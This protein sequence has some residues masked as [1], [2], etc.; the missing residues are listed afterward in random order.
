MLSNRQFAQKIENRRKS[1]VSV[2]IVFLMITST[3]LGLIS[4]VSQEFEV[5]SQLVDADPLSMSEAQSTDQGGQG[6][7]N[8]RMPSQY[9]LQMHDAL[10]DL[11]WSDSSTM[12]G[13]IE[14]ISALS[15]DPGY[16]LMLEESA[17]D[18]H[19]NDGINDLDDLDD[20]ND[21]IY[22][23]L[24]RFDGCVETDPY[25]HD[26]DGIQDHLDWDDDN[27]GILEG[28]I[29]YD[30]LEALGLD[31]R[32]V[33]MHRYVE[34]STIHPLTGQPVGISYRAD[35]QPFDHD[36]DGVTDEDTDGSGAGRY[37][38]DDDNDG[39]IDQFRWPCDFD[40]DGAQD[41]FDDDDDN[42]GTADWLD[43]APYDSTIFT[44]MDA[45]GNLWD[46]YRIWTF[47]EYR[48]YSAGV[49][50]IDLEAAKVDAN[51]EFDFAGGETGDGAAGT[52]AF[53]TISDGDLDGDGIPNFIDPDNDDDDVPDSS[54]TDDDNDGLLDMYDP[55]DDNDGIPD[56]CWNI[57]VNG[58]GLNDYTGL[59]STPYQTPGA[60]ADNDGFIDCEMDY[61]ADLDDDRFRPFDQNYNAIW[62][63]LDDGYNGETPGSPEYV[64]QER[65]DMGGTPTPD[66]AVQTQFLA[67]DFAYDIDNDQIENENDSFPLDQNSEAWIATCTSQSNPNPANP[68]PRCMTRRASFAQFN[69]WDGDGISNWDDVDDDGDGIIDMLDIDWDCDLDN[70]ALL[71]QINGSKYRDDGPNDVD[72][73]IDGDGLS[74]DIDWDDDNDGINDLY[75]PD[76]GNCGKVDYDATDSFATPY[77]PLGDGADLDGSEDNQDYS[78]NT[79]N[80]WS[81]VWNANPFADVILN[82]N[83][84]DATTNPPEGGDVPEFYWF[85]F[86]RWSSYNGANEWDI[87]ADGDSLI[88]GLD[89]DQD[90][91]GMPD[92][93][94][95]DE[96]NDGLM[97]V[98]DLKMGGTMNLTQCG[99]TVG[100]LGSGFTCGYAYAIAYHMPLTGTNAQ[101]GSPY[102]TR[103]DAA[104]DQGAGGKSTWACT[105]GAQGGCWHYDFGG[106]GDVESAISYTQIQDNRDAF[107]TWMGLLT[108]IWQWNFDDTAVADTV[109]FPD[110]LGADLLHNAED[111]DVDGD[112]TNNTVDLDED[113]DNIYD[114]NDVDDDND[115]LWD[116]FEVDT[117]DD[118]DDDVDQDY[119][120]DFFTGL[121]CDDKDDDGND[122]DVD[123]DGWFQA[124]WD[125]GIM[126]QGLKSPKF[127]DVDNDNDG[128]PDSEDPDDDNNG[129]MDAQQELQPGCFTG[130]EQ[131]PFDHDNDGIVDWADNDFDGDGISNL[132]EAQI[133]IT[134]PFDHDNDGL[135]D[136]IDKD[137]DEDGMQD[138][139]EVLLWPLRFDTESTNP[140]DH[141][142]YGGGLG[143]ANPLDPSTGP[144]AID[145]DD[146]NDSRED[147]DWDHLEENFISDPC[148]NGAQSSD[149]DH[150][151]NCILDADDKAPTFITMDMPDNLW[152]DAQSPAIFRGHVDWL[153]PTTS[154]LEAAPGLPVQVHIEWT[155]NNTTAIETIDVITNMWGNFTVGQF[156]FPEDL[157]VG[158]NTTYRV[159]AEVTEMFAFNG[160]QSQSYF[161]GAEANMTVD[162]SAWTY[163]RSDEQ[164]FWLDF[165]AH[166]A[167]DWTRGLYDNRI[168]NSPISFE[169]TDGPGGV[170]GNTTNPSNYSGFNNDGYRTDDDG[171]AS[172][173]FVQNLGANG[174]WKQVRWNS[175]MDNGVGLIP[176]G[177]EEI[178]WNDLTKTHDVLLDNQGMPLR[179]NYTNTSLPAGD[180]EIKASV[181]PGLANEW[182]FPYLH[183][184]SSDPFPV[185]VMHRM[186][187]EG[188]MI[189]DGLSAVYY[190]DGT[191][192]NGDG[193][194]GNWATLFHQQALNA[195]GV[196]F[197]EAN[198]LRPYPS[199][200]D[201]DPDNLPGEAI[202][203]RSF[204]TVNATHWF[205]SL[206]N[207][208]DGDLP[209]CG[210]VDPTDPSSPVRCEIVPEMN[211]GESFGVQGKVTNRTND[212]WDQDPIALQID[213]DGNGQFMGSQETA[214]TQRPVMKNGEATFEYNWTWYSQYAAGTYG[215][216]VDFTNNAY[217]FTGNSTNLAATGAYINVT[218]VGTT[219]FQM[220]SVPRLYRNSTTIIEARLLDNSLQPLRQSP[221]TWTW[222]YDGRS[223]V[224]FTDDMGTFA[225]PFDI[226]PEDDLGNYSL[227]FEYEGNRLMK[228]NVDSQSVWVVSRTYVSVISSD[229]NIRESGDRWDFTAQITDD[230]KTATIRDAGGRELSGASSPNG[231]LVDVIYE[232][233]SF[234]GVMHR[235]VVATLAPNAGLISLP[236]PQIDG[237]HLCFYDGNGDGIPDRD[238]NGNGQLD[239]SEAIGC[240][241]ANVSPLSPQLLREDPDSFLPD[242]FGPVSVY[243]RFRETLPNEGCEM[244][245]VEYLSMQ[246]KWD[247]CVDEIGNDH[248]RV[249]MAY[250]A[251]G[252]ALIGRTSLDVDDQIVYTSE[253]DPLTGEVVPKPM[254]VT[255]KLTD[256]LDTNLTFRNVRVNYEMVN[257]PAGPVACFNGVTDINGQFAITCPL[258]DVMAGTA[259]VTVTYS[260]WDNNDAYRYQNKTVQTEFDVFSNST[261]LIDEVGPFKSSVETFVA[262]NNGTA[263]PVLYL[264]ESFHIDAI[265]T[266]S[267]GQYVGGKCLN[268]YLDPQKNVRP[269][270]SINTRESDGMVEWFSGDPSQNPGLKGVETTGGELEGFRLLRVAFEPDTNVPGGCDKDSSNVLNGSHMD[271]VVLVRSRVDLQVKTSWSHVNN[272]GLDNDDNVHGEI[273]L[274]RDRLD[275]AVEN[276]E[277]FFVR[278]YWDFDAQEWV[279]EGRNES[280]T[281]EQGIASFDWA[282]SGT[283]CEGEPCSGDWRIKAYYPGS[284]FFAES[285]DNITHEVHYQKAK[286]VDS[287]EG[288]FTPSTIMAILIVLLGAAIAG[289]MYYQRVVARRQVEALRG[290]LTDTMMQLQAANEYIAIIFD[291]YKQLVKHF[292]RHGFMKKVY[293]TTREFESAVRGAFHM[294]PADQL[295]AFVAIFEEARYSDHEIGPSHRDRAIS[296]LNAITQ[297]L[298]MALGDGGMI[299]RGEQHE[300]KLYDGLTKAGEFVAADGTVKQ[301][302][303]DEN[304]DTSNFKI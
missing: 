262:P 256:E 220:T 77:Y 274:L 68:D 265:L 196:S 71:H 108:G 79:D 141:D 228:G 253:I 214:Y 67:L 140:W 181:I 207:G 290:I 254:V 261:L 206:V 157:V 40:N 24:E 222:S 147:N 230:N 249:Q 66:D 241:K 212:A 69:D 287:S 85:M 154:M 270:S 10:W 121:N 15:L 208:G 239:D 21:G 23:L 202:N 156:L 210:Q 275:L 22:D 223:G 161:V 176:G 225:I 278:E 11:T 62:D 91:D 113:Y 9:G 32:N 282:F 245:E 272:N 100:Q 127:Y 301:A 63:W 109:G 279:V 55:D 98:N 31:P 229:P 159:Y 111:G 119:G 139:D 216:R 90:A 36:N 243:L 292:R 135:R 203:L 189:V 18:D 88:N 252:F 76:D 114:W 152:L 126:S 250:N 260:A 219:Q 242:G 178:V 56:V 167:A 295:D 28:P 158:D 54:D 2:G 50:F 16:G 37:D 298:S 257:S 233:L 238:S 120:A 247:P 173:T 17:A 289:V 86:T 89:T 297:S 33:S 137:D 84:F 163:F 174:T 244:L 168:K 106:D 304:A 118:L 30:A 269:L 49:N 188:E 177:Y 284:T 175:T 234:D 107:I 162:Y 116:F 150:D 217:Y 263:F 59:N 4:T 209:P 142:D 20:D 14:D 13:Q 6:E 39:R 192:N 29:D 200:W 300:A 235:Q 27:D 96:G 283:T 103:P 187:I 215:V 138:V 182:P 186:N 259:R 183:G 44:P 110:E 143:I 213:I 266:Q 81:M 19:D 302:G 104:F 74:N 1:T 190:W 133:S 131:H 232:G 172:L 271:I 240:L 42:D 293:E 105:P 43:A 205:I 218:V 75:D 227:Q 102:S 160:N 60:D 129:V 148:Y 299:T 251:N 193:T 273:A 184:D 124:V 191:I 204:L 149:W 169:I 52:P 201:G 87:D 296:T 280:Y 134:A 194:F 237:S 115:G 132:V 41:Y 258:S 53:T 197:E 146:D 93:W 101:F 136:D 7:W 211:T 286:V 155:G 291:C 35:Q 82:Y 267:N 26:N 226:N 281:N 248:F 255:G 165:K 34:S 83:G 236:E 45:S 65:Y 78:D 153:N 170:F 231:G 199:L 224:N 48:T 8:G 246:G 64:Y 122:Q 25:D 95:Q 180:I 185:R 61:D 70:D 277:I 3:W 46:N 94:D 288:I 47:N 57:D 128:V 268:I 264:K 80:Y 97:D 5:E 12:Y 130:E 171:W 285:S 99:M 58:D 72:S 117:N 112:F 38:E 123:E 294:V 144:D 125:K 198:T 303:I 92:W 179:Y 221:V 73:D 166:Y 195:A 145:N 151:N 51:D 164:P 276:E